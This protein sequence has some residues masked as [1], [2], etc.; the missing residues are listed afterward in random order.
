[1]ADKQKDVVGVLL[2][3]IAP[4]RPISLKSGHAVSRALRE[5]GWKVVEID[6]GP[7]LPEQL[8]QQGVTV[9]WLALHGPLGEDGCVQGLCEVLRLPYTGSGVRG[10]AVAMDKIAT[11]RA[12]AGSPAASEVALPRDLTWRRGDA[13]PEHLGFPVMVKTPEGGST[14]GIRKCHDAAEL[15]AGLAYCLGFAEEVLVEQFVAGDEIT[16]AV[17]EGQALPV[18]KIEPDTGFFD[19]EAKYQK[20]RTRYLVPAP[21]APD[22]AARA[23]AAA[24]AAYRVLGLAG[25]ARAD[26]IV[27]AE[28]TPWFLEINTL[29]GMTETSLSPMAAGQLGMDFGDLVE[30]ILHG[31]RLR[32]MPELGLEGIARLRAETPA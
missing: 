29:P 23:Q 32:V 11:K 20:G 25:V 31:A 7:D 26:F 24:T 28:G 22:T 14:L 9:A 3:G 15:E 8:R 30:R 5:R 4:E 10:S 27:D 2:G 17:L 19:F 12:L 18:V 1:M 13:L 6:V 16:V 21:I